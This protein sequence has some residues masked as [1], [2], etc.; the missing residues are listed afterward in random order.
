MAQSAQEESP[1][2]VLLIEVKGFEDFCQHEGQV[3]AE[4]AIGDL[5]RAVRTHCGRGHDHVFRLTRDRIAAV[6]PQTHT[7]GASHIAMRI[8]QAAAFLPSCGGSPVTIAI[9]I[10]VVGPDSTENAADVMAR[11]E[12]TLEP[13]RGQTVPFLSVT[14]AGM[15]RLKPFSL[16]AKFS[17]L[18]RQSRDSHD[19]RGGFGRS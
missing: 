9:G 7:T 15:R 3:A 8:R 19:R 10:A 1:L 16:F 13:A 18:F 12:H 4:A 2:A 17:E 5:L 6:C 11:V 14:T